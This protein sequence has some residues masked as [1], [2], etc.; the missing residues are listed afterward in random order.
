MKRHS[1]ISRNDAPLISK[2]KLEQTLG[3]GNFGTVFSAKQLG[4][5]SP[6]AIKA[7]PR[8]SADQG[9]FTENEVLSLKHT[10]HPHIVKLFEVVES[11]DEVFLVMERLEGGELFDYMQEHECL[12]EPEAADLFKQ[13]ISAVGYLHSIGMCHRDLK[14]ENL[15]FSDKSYTV[16]KLVDFG[17][18]KR[19]KHNERMQTRTGTPCY[20]SPEFLRGDYTQKTDI[21]SAGV[22]LYYLLS[23]EFPF[24]GD[25]N[26][27]TFQ[28]I[29]NGNYSLRGGKWRKVSPSAKDLLRSMLVAEPKL[30]ACAKELLEHPWVTSSRPI[31]RATDVESLK[32]F[33]EAKLLK[34]TLI[35]SMASHSLDSDFS[36]TIGLFKDLEVEGAISLKEF[37]N[38]LIS[39][40]NFPVKEIDF[41]LRGTGFKGEITCTELVAALGARRFLTNQGKIEESFKLFKHPRRQKIT[42]EEITKALNLEPA[43]W[44]WE[45]LHIG[46]TGLQLADLITYLTN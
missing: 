42:R 35:L 25:T 10:D 23:G 8:T 26:Q 4:S 3:T 29:L 31:L 2:Y 41:L 38:L 5:K 22:I 44:L 40:S 32:F 13:L 14:L 28:L 46:P 36:S 21:W 20:M 33:S 43:P 45:D 37:R 18:A 6:R 15:M 16:L 7:I 24:L 11:A 30:R 1:F 19:V 34:K 27:E 39:Q 12:K 17:L 9:A